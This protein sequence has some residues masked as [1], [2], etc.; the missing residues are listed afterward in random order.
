MQD[1]VHVRHRTPADSGIGDAAFNET[2]AVCDGGEVLPPPR[3]EVVQD[4]DIVP[5]GDKLFH[6][7]RA[8]EARSAGNQESHLESALLGP[9]FAPC[10]NPASAPGGVGREDDCGI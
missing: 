9:S 6:Q 1:A 8:D 10:R 2:D 7:V 3:R 4:D 5:G